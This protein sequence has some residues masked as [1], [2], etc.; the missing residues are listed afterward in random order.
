[1]KSWTKFLFIFGLYLCIG[2][3]GYAQET[4][5]SQIGSW[6]ILSGEVAFNEKF[7]VPFNFQLRTY[8]LASRQNHIVGLAGLTYRLRRHRFGIGYGYLNSDYTFLLLENEAFTH[9]HR[10]YLNYGHTHKLHRFTFHHRWQYEQRSL[11]QQDRT[12]QD[13]R[14]RYRF[15]LQYPLSSIWYVKASEE[16]I[17]DMDTIDFAQ[18][19]ALVSL[20]RRFNKNLSMEFGYLNFGLRNRNYHRLQLKLLVSAQLKRRL[21]PTVKN[22]VAELP[23][24]HATDARTQSGE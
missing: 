21:A 15:Q 17:L 22:S 6:Y 13:Q 4:G 18:N 7:S 19:R 12:F 16:I 23:F 24:E 8:E 9:E 11:Q 3:L 14:F 2:T 10:W 1:M 20:G 5:E